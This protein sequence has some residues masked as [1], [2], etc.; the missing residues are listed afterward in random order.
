[1]VFSSKRTTNKQSQNRQ[2]TVA[3]LRL[4]FQ[5]SDSHLQGKRRARNVSAEIAQKN[6]A[7]EIAA[8]AGCSI[9][10]ARDCKLHCAV[11][12]RRRQGVGR[13]SADIGGSLKPCAGEI[14]IVSLASSGCTSGAAL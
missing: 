10:M 2:F 1:L 7:N 14:R 11:E 5:K 12:V 4:R 3:R 9:A 8:I 13:T 6:W